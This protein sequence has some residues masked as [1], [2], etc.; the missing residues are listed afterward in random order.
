MIPDNQ[1]TS[2][3]IPQQL[4]AFIRDDSSYA[5]FVAF[6]EAYY[7]W[8][9]Q[10]NNVTDRSKNILNY[11]DIDNTTEEFI[12]YFTEEYISYFPQEILANKP[13]VIKIAKQLYQSKG[14]TASYK[15]LFRILFNSDVDFFFTKDAVLKSSSGVWYVA[16]NLN[17]DTTDQNWLLVNN[18]PL[19]SLRVFGETTKSFATLENVIFTGT[20]MQVYI[21]NPIRQFNSGEF[22]RVVDSNNKDYIIDI[23][24]AQYILRAKIVGQINEVIIDPKNQGLLYQP[25]DPLVFYGGLI[26]GSNTGAS[27]QVTT[28][29]KGS[30]SSIRLIT[31]GYGYRFSP[32]TIIDITADAV[33]LPTAQVS[34]VDA[35]PNNTANVF[36]VPTDVIATV[37]NSYIGNT[38]AGFGPPPLGNSVYTFANNSSANANTSL[39]NAFSY[40]EFTTYPI[41][42]I[43][44]TSSGTG[45][46]TTPQVSA[47]SY[48]P[49]LSG[50]QGNLAN[51]GILAPI[52]IQSGGQGYRVNDT[53]IFTGGSGYGAVAN[54][55]SVNIANGNT[56]TSVVYVRTNPQ[57]FALGGMGYQ[58]SLPS[59]S[60]NSANGSASGAVLY[61]PGVLGDGATF[62][63]QAD[64]V[65]AITSVTITDAGQDYS[66]AP[67]VSLAVQDLSIITQTSLYLP[68]KG[69]ILF[70]GSSYVTATYSAIVDSTS[71]LSY[72]SNSSQIIYNVRVYN[73]TARPAYNLPLKLNSNNQ[74]YLTLTNSY[75]TI[76]VASRYD[77]TGVLTYGDGS[78]IATASFINGL[79]SSSGQYLNTQG[80]PSGFSVLQNQEYN[81]FT[82]QLTSGVEIAKYRKVL[83]DLLHPT[84][85]K[86][87]GR[88]TIESLAE[89][90]F[91]ASTGFHSGF[92]LAY[93]TGAPSFATMVAN[94]S[95]P[96]TNTV[97]FTFLYGANLQQILAVG[98]E[99]LMTTANGFAIQSEIESVDV[100]SNT[101]TLVD[102]SWLSFANVAYVTANAGSNRINISSLTGSYDIVN[103]GTYS[104]PTQPLRDIVFTGDTVVISNNAVRTVSNVD[105]QN[106]VV[107]L[108]SNLS[109]YANS[110]SLMTVNRTFVTSN[111][112]DFGAVGV[113]YFP[114]ITTEDGN[115]II[116]ENGLEILLG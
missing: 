89:T 69:D 40:I 9:E 59:L 25:G 30:L 50:G 106:N 80:Q 103:N 27:A 23:A 78:A 76:N 39:A 61:V 58:Y 108:T 35:S 11:A 44:L 14:T 110:G 48:Y 21:S 109:A 71:I 49:T 63:A 77:S 46:A 33:V 1:K 7:E 52:Q 92:P 53:I 34:T 51:L 111:V 10:T 112:Y 8:L 96:S 115:I 98:N 101:V 86:V 100:S 12:N 47:V 28:T 22:I 4:P 32:N 105:Y 116:T 73:Y 60:V 19:G 56:I 91:S 29:T 102:H 68:Q 79:N 45:I 57:L 97:S 20:K 26:E 70:Q 114:V 16:K 94:T 15:F 85:L 62:A 41:S 90:D 37:A 5:T 104:N 74:Q 84:G 55:A 65:G 81:N 42:S 54:V 17:V 67:S 64:R 93:Y 95:Y 113:Q 43:L 82:Y 72:N 107:Y 2:L 75:N 36:F 6:L 13:A 24:G 88:Y 87:L 83:L 99:L 18:L 66:S 38:A 31:G 3:L